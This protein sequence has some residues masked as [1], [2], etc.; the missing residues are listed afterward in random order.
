M[1]R[2][3]LIFF[4]FASVL[5]SS[6]GIFR[7]STTESKRKNKLIRIPTDEKGKFDYLFYEAAKQKILENYTEALA[8]YDEC[9]KLDPNNAVV[10]YEMAD[11]SLKLGK[12][13]EAL[14][15]A[16]IAVEK[17]PTNKWFKVLLAEANKKVYKYE[18]AAKLYGQLFEMVP[19]EI[20]YLY[21]QANALL[22]V[23]KYAEA[24]KV[25]DRVEELTGVS[26]DLSLQKERILLNMNKPEKALEEI[27]K[28][29]EAFPAESRYLGLLAEL[30]MMTDN[31]LKA[32]EIYNRILE[33]EPDNP[34]INLSLADY[35][36]TVGQMDKSFDY[37]KKAFQ[38]KQMDIDAK[39]KVLL[40]YYQ[41]S[42]T[43][44]ILR[45]HAMGLA[46]TLVKVHPDEAKSYSI[47]G[48]LLYRDKRI[49]EAR[50]MFMKVISIDSSK[51]IVWEQVMII[52]SELYDFKALAEISEA[53]IALFP[54]QP[55]TYLFNGI[56]NMRTGNTTEAAEALNSGRLLVVDDNKLL[57]EFWSNLGEVYSIEK[58]Y[59][60]S[61]QAFDKSLAVQPNNSYVLNNYSYYLAL[62]G[63]FLEKARLMAKK[64]N[65]LVPNSASY[66]DTYGWVLF[67]AGD[68]EEAKIWIE[69][70]MNNSGNRNAVILE[71]FGDVLYKL[72]Q[73]ESALEYW[74]KAQQAGKGTDKLSEKIETKIWVE[75]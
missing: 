32:L 26:E 21:E 6:C 1:Q 51:Y 67:R 64:A 33:K 7:K 38:S 71:H 15:L 44:T 39:M 56:A 19:T 58:D 10:C 36:E 9:H 68:Y 23:R 2:I 34:M 74:N 45:Q 42:E 29:S 40:T 4:L 31:K 16:A 22:I 17:D 55:M 41:L 46:E 59:V 30:Y 62:R 50:D 63:E 48:D 75:E 3:I 65:D 27:K 8:I 25:Y 11:I 66:Q 14:L 20:D 5:L 60:Q 73:P 35:Y 72:N 57:A 54:N 24:V 53:A 47:Y 13:Q 18:E 61:D 52:N 70:A 49:T 12:N 43:D 69:K 28:L 37:V